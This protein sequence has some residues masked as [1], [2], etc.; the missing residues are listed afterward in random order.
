MLT[1]KVSSKGQVTLPRVVRQA[2][3]VKAGERVLF[4]VEN[5]TVL[6]E[7][8]GPTG[9]SALVGSLRRYA[10]K[11]KTLVE[12][13]SVVKKEVARAAAQEG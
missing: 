1:A 9:A 13:R 7:A 11:R 3:D 2:L 4:V 6:L 5:E 8:M 12:A 10:G